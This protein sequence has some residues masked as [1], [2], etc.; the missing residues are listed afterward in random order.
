MALDG[1]MGIL[2]RRLKASDSVTAAAVALVMARTFSEGAGAS[3]AR[4]CQLLQEANF[5][6]Y[7]AFDNGSPVGGLTAHVVPI[8]SEDGY[9]L[10][11]YDI[12]VQASHQRLGIGMGLMRTVLEA[13]K[14]SGMSSAFVPADNNDQHALDFYRAV[15]GQAQSVTFFNFRL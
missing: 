10:F 9:E 4:L 2:I 13:G 8:T 12:A 14:E 15:G 11:I 7:G 3:P 1:H 5:W 6:F